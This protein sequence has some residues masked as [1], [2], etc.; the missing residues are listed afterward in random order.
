VRTRQRTG[1]AEQR[2][3]HEQ[4]EAGPVTKKNASQGSCAL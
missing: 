3:H 2:R 4:R 1:A